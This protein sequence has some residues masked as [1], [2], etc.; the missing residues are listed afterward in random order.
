MDLGCSNKP[1]TFLA[2]K[3][4]YLG[5]YFYSCPIC[6]FAQN[7]LEQLLYPTRRQIDVYVNSRL[8][9]GWL[10][11]VRSVEPRPYTTLHHPKYHNDTTGRKHLGE[12]RKQKLVST[13]SQTASSCERCHANLRYLNHKHGWCPAFPMPQGVLLCYCTTTERTTRTVIVP[14]YWRRDRTSQ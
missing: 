5:S 4:I 2:L 13:P 10:L 1:L 11:L 12:K 3:N 6:R 7:W 14:T 8:P 9:L